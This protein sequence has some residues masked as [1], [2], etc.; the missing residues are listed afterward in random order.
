MKLL[1]AAIFLS[2]PFLLLAQ[3]HDN[4]WLFGYSSNPIDQNFGGSVMDFNTL[5]PDIYYEYRDA[6]F[7]EV[8]A[9][10]CSSSGNLQ[11]YCNGLFVATKENEV[12]ENGQFLNPGPFRDDM[13]DIGYILFQGAFIIPVPGSNDQRY[14]LFHADREYSTAELGGHSSHLYYTLVN[15]FFN[16]GIGKVIEKNN[17]IVQ[18]TLSLG[19][20]TAVRHANG[21]D[22]WII[23]H[24]LASPT[25]YRILITPT[26]IQNLGKE[27]TGV[28]IPEDGIGQAV[29]SPDGSFFARINSISLTE[30]QYVD[31]YKF[32]R[33][34][35]LLG[36][37]VQ[38][39]YDEDAYAAGIAISPNS[40]YLYVSS[41]TQI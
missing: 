36:N 3:E 19:K 33:C 16:N 24:E 8:N 6:N 22:W 32:D 31:I 27:S 11:F 9:S 26:G 7:Q 15:M 35:G 29:F 5:P 25:Y 20:L 38:I 28:G 12:M 39:H 30:G 2:F 4:I 1:F 21:R 18:D 14:Y 37:Q 13:L 34:S 10:I 17:V 41:Y 23:F 40:R